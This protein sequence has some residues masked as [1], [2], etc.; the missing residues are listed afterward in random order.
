MSVLIYL[1]KLAFCIWIGEMIFFAAVIAPNVFRILSRSD[2]ASM[3]AMI[4]PK[5]FAIGSICGAIILIVTL[6]EFIV[7]KKQLP[8]ATIFLCLVPMCIFMYCQFKL[9]PE[10]LAIQPEA[11]E[12]PKNSQEEIATKFKSLHKISTKLN[13]VALLFLLILLA[14]S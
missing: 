4:F 7:L 1:K 2:A 9:S 10:L 11:I 3:Q 14:F 8:I 12:L 6:I 13:V 5:Y